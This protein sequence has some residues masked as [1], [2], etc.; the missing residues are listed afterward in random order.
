MTEKQKE[1]APIERLDHE[2]VDCCGTCEH[3]FWVMRSKFRA[4]DL[5]NVRLVYAQREKLTRQ[6]CGRHVYSEQSNAVAL[7][8]ELTMKGAPVAA[9]EVPP[10]LAL[11]DVP[12]SEPA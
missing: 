2:V 1:P 4:C 8:I 10:Q 9:P 3:A 11:A 6:R 12:L 7:R 5:W